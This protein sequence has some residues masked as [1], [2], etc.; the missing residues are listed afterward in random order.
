MNKISKTLFN[1]KNPTG[2]EDSGHRTQPYKIPT[3]QEKLKMG[4][5]MPDKMRKLM[6]Y[7]IEW[8]VN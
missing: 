6:S 5:I 7:L 8:Q 3:R 2:K 1:P 4:R